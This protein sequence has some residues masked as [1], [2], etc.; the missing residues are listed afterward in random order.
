MKLDHI[1]NNFDAYIFYRTQ[2]I[3]LL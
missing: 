3:N 1:N 2:N